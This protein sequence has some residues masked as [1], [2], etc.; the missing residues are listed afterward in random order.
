MSFPEVAVG[1]EAVVQALRSRLKL[2]GDIVGAGTGI[3]AVA[4]E[5]C[6]VEH[7]LLILPRATMARVLADPAPSGACGGRKP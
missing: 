1:L 4:V 2:P 5:D 7:V 3:S 6:M